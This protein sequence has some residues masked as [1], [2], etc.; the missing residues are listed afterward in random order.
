MINPETIAAPIT[1]PGQAAVTVVRVSGSRVT[2]VINA[3]VSAARKVISKPRELHFS[4]ILDFVNSNNQTKANILDHALVVYFPGPESFSGEDC[5]EFHLHGG[6]FIRARLLE[7]LKQLNV[8]MANPGEFTERAYHNGR[9]DLAQAEAV[10]DLIAAETEAQAQLAE[11][12]LAGNL[13]KAISELGE[14]LRT[15]LAEIEAYID[16]PDEDITPESWSGW[17]AQLERLKLVLD[18]YLASYASGRLLRE[19]AR[20]VLLGLPNAGKS[21]L[22]NRLLGEDRV[23]VTPTP[24]TTRDSIEVKL[25]LDGV[26]VGIWDTAGLEE[27]NRGVGEIEQLGIARSWKMARQADLNVFVYDASLGEP[28]SKHLSDIRAL[29][30]PLLLVGNKSDLATKDNNS[31]FGEELVLVSAKTGE[32]ID[33]LLEAIKERLFFKSTPMASVQIA[34]QRHFD[35]LEKAA[36]NVERGL[37]GCK[38][39]VPAELISAD[40]RAGLS[41][42]NE[43]IGVTENE[44]ILGKIFSK[45]C[46]GK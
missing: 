5:L 33:Q 30:R 35:C 21:S 4:S 2:E 10:A 38:N 14:P 40:I 45:F 41:A 12:Q 19:G 43:I 15:L 29:K 9:L 7:N 25:S 26:P 22:T 24:G 27:E 17:K 8:R 31:Q 46:I 28:Q 32:G 3:L 36:E 6:T 18:C 44:E 11:R 37:L 1:A 20:V 13:S 23:I 16:F 39:T 34:N 42:L